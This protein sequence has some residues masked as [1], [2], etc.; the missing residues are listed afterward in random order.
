MLPISQNYAHYL[1]TALQAWGAYS[2]SVEP[3]A[4]LL[5]AYSLSI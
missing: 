3:Y 4:N 2:D 5:Y 1:A